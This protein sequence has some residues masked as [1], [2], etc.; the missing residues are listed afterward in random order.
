MKYCPNCNI[1]TYD[2][3]DMFCLNCGGNL[4][5]KINYK[6]SHQPNVHLRNQKKIKIITLEIIIVS[7]V[8]FSFSAFFYGMFG[9]NSF[10]FTFSLFIFYVFWIGK[11]LSYELE[12][13]EKGVTSY[14]RWL[15]SFIH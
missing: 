13:E 3:Q 1:S 9:F 12:P 6:S 7:L 11:S 8:F 10:L 15:R 14:G 5:A 2:N 4:V